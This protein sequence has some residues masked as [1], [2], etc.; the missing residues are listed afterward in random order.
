MY[1]VCNFEKFLYRTISVCLYVGCLAFVINR[2]Y[3]C[4]AKYLSEPEGIAESYHN[5][6]DLPFPLFTFC[7]ANN[8]N[9]PPRYYNDYVTRK[10]NVIYNDYVLKS[11]YVG[12]GGKIVAQ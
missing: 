6:G 12:S 4:F 2:G 1:K 11:E 10:C 9:H 3:N 5:I 8:N 7:P